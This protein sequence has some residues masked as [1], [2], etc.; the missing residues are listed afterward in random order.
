MFSFVQERK[1]AAALESLAPAAPSN[2]A[3]APPMERAAAL[4]VCN[5]LLLRASSAYGRLVLEAPSRLDPSVAAEAVCHLV[6]IRLRMEASAQA[7]DG[8]AETDPAVAAFRWEML[9]N[10]VAT[11]T[12]GSALSP[13]AARAMRRCWHSMWLARRAREEAVRAMTAY[14][15]AY[16]ADPIPAINGKRATDDLLRKLG[17][18]LPPM[19]R[20]KAG[21]TAGKPA[22]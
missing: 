18:T 22:R 14:A 3:S 5:A 4:I 2:V 20:P 19:F 10:E 6:D 1:A 21:K 15:K 17:G 9:A 11:L 16:S 12:M 7:L 13:D 8:R